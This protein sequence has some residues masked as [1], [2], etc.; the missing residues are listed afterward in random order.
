MTS[1]FNVYAARVKH[2]VFKSSPPPSL[3]SETLSTSPTF[4]HLKSAVIQ[5]DGCLLPPQFLLSSAL[6]DLD[7]DL[8][9]TRKGAGVLQRSQRLAETLCD[10]P[11]LTTT[12]QKLRIKGFMATQ[13]DHIVPSFASLRSLTLLTGSSVTAGT[14]AAL[15]QL[16]DLEDLY[17]H[18]SCVDADDFTR[19]IST[20]TAQPF[21]SLRS[22]RIRAQRPLFCAILDVVPR[23]TLSSLYLETEEAGQGPSAWHPTFTLLAAKAS[24]TLLDLTL[25]QI[26]DPEDPEANPTTPAADPRLALTALQ[27]LAALRALR[28]L[29]LDAALPPALTDADIDTLARWWPALEHLTLGALPDGDAE[30]PA[31]THAALATLAR[32]CPRLRTLALPQ[33]GRAHV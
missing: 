19:A 29:T 31:L 28:R 26:L 25:D 6:Q 17:V 13:L 21:S 23:G 12:L 14:L 33:I 9:G 18:A 2:I 4:P 30:E 5:G 32:R 3:T 8:R 11:S 15:G 27:P 16:M 10:I 24:D 22:L 20:Q 7:V 1:E